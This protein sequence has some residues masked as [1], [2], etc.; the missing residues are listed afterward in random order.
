MQA[1]TVTLV[2]TSVMGLIMIWLAARVIAGRVKGDVIIGD[3]ENLDL[4]YRIR[5]QGNFAEYTP[6]FL[7]LLGAL[8]L[9][10]GNQ[11]VLMVLAVVFVV[12]RILHVFGMG[13]NANLKFRQIGMIATFLSIAVASIYGLAIALM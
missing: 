13:E 8:E 7:I 2:T 12:A 6:L 1:L 3:G 4:L 5:A 11:T 9:S 10:A